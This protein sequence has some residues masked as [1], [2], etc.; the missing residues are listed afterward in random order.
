MADLTI[1]I[2][3]DITL[4]GD[5]TRLTNSKSISGIN[6]IYRRI[7]KLPASQTTELARFLTSEH[8]DTG[9]VALDVEDTRYI[10]VTNLDTANTI[11]LV[12]GIS[13]DEATDA[14]AEEST[15]ILLDAGKSFMLGT[16]HDGIG[17]TVDSDSDDDAANSLVDLV[18]LKA[19]CGGSAVS[20]EV[21][22]ATL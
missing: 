11:E 5:R 20:V 1:K 12:M 4:N 2:L 7:V 9:A 22:I 8:T 15:T 19:V 13:T 10:R 6:N 16:I 3:E 17:T 21:F 14:A 18:W